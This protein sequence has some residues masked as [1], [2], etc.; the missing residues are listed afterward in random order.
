MTALAVL[1]RARGSGLVL[2]V[3]G[4]RE[5]DWATAATKCRWHASSHPVQPRAAPTGSSRTVVPPAS[6]IPF[7]PDASSRAKRT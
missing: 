7:D 4:D 2:S 6:L 3:H 5:E 1:A